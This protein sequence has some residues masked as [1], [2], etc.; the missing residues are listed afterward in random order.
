MNYTFKIKTS[1]GQGTD[2]KTIDKSW[3]K[4]Y[5]Q[6]NCLYW[7]NL[8]VKGRWHF[9]N[10]TVFKSMDLKHWIMM[11]DHALPGSSAGRRKNVSVWIKGAVSIN[12]YTYLCAVCACVYECVT[13]R[14]TW[15]YFSTVRLLWI[16]L[17]YYLNI[18]KNN[19]LRHFSQSLLSEGLIYIFLACF[20]LF[21]I[22]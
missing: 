18:K 3:R 7:Y 5:T 10:N 19:T 15:S 12:Q 13:S 4:K 16:F 21:S 9:P 6:R 17:Y 8:E 20:C 1:L 11:T 14:I 22:K 2:F